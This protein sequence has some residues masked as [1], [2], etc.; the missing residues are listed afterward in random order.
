[1]TLPADWPETEIVAYLQE[2]HSG[3]KNAGREYV[4]CE[5]LGISDRRFR[6]WLESQLE[7]PIASNDKGIWY[8]TC[9]K[10]WNPAIRWSVSAFLAWKKRWKRQVWMR[11]NL[12]PRTQLFDD[13]KFGRAA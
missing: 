6:E 5:A 1:M 3:P 12:H 4:I 2:N 9:P 10:D 11:T 13:K 8:C 7:H